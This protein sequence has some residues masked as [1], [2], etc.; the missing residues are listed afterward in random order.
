[1]GDFGKYEVHPVAALF[2]MIEG[3]EF[4]R[5]VADI[6]AN[7]LVEP[8]TLSNDESMILD[9][10]TRDRACA[11]AGV[12]PRYTKLGKH[13]DEQAII[14]F[15][16]SK[17]LRRRHMDVGQRSLLGVSLLPY[18]EHAAKERQREHG[19][20]A[21]GRKSLPANLPGV[22]K[23]DARDLVAQVVN[24]SGKSI[25]KAKAVKEFSPTLASDVAANKVSLDAAYKQVRDAEKAMEVPKEP[26]PSKTHVTLRTHL[27]DKVSYKLPKG[28]AKFNR[29]NEHISWAAWSWN[30]VTGCLH[31][32]KYC[33]ARELAL[34]E[35]Y[36]DAYP[37]GFTPLFHHERL[38]APANTKVPDEA[39]HDSRLR[40]VFVCSM[41]DL[42]GKWVPNEW[43]EQVHASC[44]ANPQWE[45]L[46]LTKFP[47]RY[48]GMHL[49]P[50][51]WLGTSVDEQKRVRLAEDAFRQI[52]GV[53]VKWLSLEPLL[54]PLEFSD[55]S[56][57]DWVVIGSQT[58]TEQPDGHVPAFMPHFEWVARLTAQA[59]EAGCRIYHKP[60]LLN[61]G[62]QLIQEE[63]V[64]D[65]RDDAQRELFV[66]ERPAV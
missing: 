46:M 63:P 54:A 12:D 27:G 47:R 17:N 59:R 45:Y 42:Y 62:M 10:R 24:V 32:C 35:S 26:P 18:Y 66:N 19:K 39:R 7:G 4:E 55:L 65:A 34:R 37:V 28:P 14:E 38:D 16:L 20:T 56:M 3:D 51:A 33:Y 11:K 53:R 15:I 29:T 48:V 8:I 13:Y 22:S 61:P 25:S 50:T 9:G 6:K 58:A 60:N 64:L 41:A 43:I 21:P 31:G 52:S 36:K 40:R 2:P 57:F 23:A 44:M 5:L 1:M 49:P 30:P